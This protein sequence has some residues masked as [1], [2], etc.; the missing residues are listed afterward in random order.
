MYWVISNITTTVLN[1][2]SYL[3]HNNHSLNKPGWSQVRTD[4]YE[5]EQIKDMWRSYPALVKFHSSQDSPLVKLRTHLKCPAACRLHGNQVWSTSVTS[6]HDLSDM[7]SLTRRP[8]LVRTCTQLTS[9]RTCTQLTSRSWYCV[10]DWDKIM[11]GSTVWDGCG[12]IHQSTVTL[13]SSTYYVKSKVHDCKYHVLNVM[14]TFYVYGHKVLC[15]C[16]VHI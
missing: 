7:I 9:R 16:R 6:W 11:Q 1:V 8:S 2:L 15:I 4:V 14:S 13:E 12:F 3:K 5:S 10:F